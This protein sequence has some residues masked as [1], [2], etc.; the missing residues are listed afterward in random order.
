MSEQTQYKWIPKK[1]N[2]NITDM[3]KAYLGCDD[4][5]AVLIYEQLWEC[6][7]KVEQEPVGLF[8]CRDGEYR[9]ILEPDDAGDYEELIELYT[10]PQPKD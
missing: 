2:K 10:H 4:T 9:H 3:I 5:D 8:G 1:P 6:A 7:P